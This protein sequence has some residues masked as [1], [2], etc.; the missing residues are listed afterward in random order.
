MA[1]RIVLSEAMSHPPRWTGTVE[2]YDGKRVKIAALVQ[3]CEPFE[4]L[5][6]F[7]DRL[8]DTDCPQGSLFP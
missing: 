4:D 6:E 8:L 1:R 5:R 7:L 2:W 3:E